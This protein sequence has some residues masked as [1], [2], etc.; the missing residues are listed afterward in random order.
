M[1]FD[2]LQ[3]YIQ[4]Q[5]SEQK[6]RTYGYKSETRRKGSYIGFGNNYFW[7]YRILWRCILLKSS[8]RSSF[9]CREAEGTVHTEESIFGCG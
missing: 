4:R 1:L 5:Q 7:H 9:V 3:A 2:L 6:R 8:E